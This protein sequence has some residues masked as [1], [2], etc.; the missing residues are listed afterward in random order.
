MSIYERMRSW[1]SERLGVSNKYEV[2]R[3]EQVDTLLLHHPIR[4]SKHWN[5]QV[6][7]N[8]GYLGHSFLRGPLLQDYQLLLLIC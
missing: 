5:S 7:I 4:A 2:Y 3:Q 6:S 8:W 1:E